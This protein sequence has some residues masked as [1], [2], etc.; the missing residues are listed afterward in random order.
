MLASRYRA[1]GDVTIRT[2]KQSRFVIYSLDAIF[3]YSTNYS[4]SVIYCSTP[5]GIRKL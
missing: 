2:S 5:R 1:E 4:F 3:L